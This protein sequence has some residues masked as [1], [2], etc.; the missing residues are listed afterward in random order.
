MAGRP[1]LRK[2]ENDIKERGGEEWVLGEIASGR[3]I[4]DIA[5]ELGISRRMLYTWRD[6]RERRDRLRPLWSEA[7]R[8]SAE[9]DVETAMAHFDRLDAVVGLDPVTGEPL[10]R[11]PAS[12]EVQLASSRA[13]YLQWLAARKDPDTYGTQEA[14]VAVNLNLGSLHLDALSQVKTREA[15]PAPPVEEAD[16]E[17]VE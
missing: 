3:R 6:R 5:E 8:M 17:V 13:K 9:A 15:L 4:G 14:Q 2:L 12:S 1:V 7:V 11:V 10:R 16:F